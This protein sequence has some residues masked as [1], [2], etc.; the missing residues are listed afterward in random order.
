MRVN[1]KHKKS[2]LL[3]TYH[4]PPD[5]EVGAIRM[6]RLANYLKNHGWDVGVLTVQERYYPDRDD[7]VTVEGITLYRTRMFESVR[8]LF[9]RIKNAFRQARA[10]LGRTERDEPAPPCD[11]SDAGVRFRSTRTYGNLSWI[12]RFV[13]SLI[14]CPDDKQGWIPFAFLKCLQLSNRYDI[15]YS[16][17]P[18]F[19]VNLAP[20]LA[21]FFIRKFVWVAEF[22]DPWMTRNKRYFISSGLSNW[23]EKRCEAMVMKR[24]TKIVVVNEAIERDMID[25]YPLVSGKIRVFYNGYDETEFADMP[26]ERARKDSDTTT[27][28]HA[29]SFYHGRDPGLLLRPLAELVNEGTLSRGRIAVTFLG[30]GEYEGESVLDLA[31]ALHIDG[32]VQCLG[33]LPHKQCLAHIRDADIL[34]LF[35]INQPLQVP[36]KLFEYFAFRKRILSISSGGITDE[37]LDR[38]HVGISVP[39]DDFVAIKSAI[40]TL[41]EAPGFAASD[42]EIN[43]YRSASIFESLSGELESLLK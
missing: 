9:G 32:I 38:M 36:A 23:L 25:R 8:F 28:V 42:E 4:F 39:P 15:V 1:G 33:F 10:A 14:W 12:S 20:L 17:C 19:S 37:L 11:G 31:R 30:D 13:L 7:S 2:I 16:S 43:R 40:V 3:V 5:A 35:N 6:T 21:S 29:G 24:S 27:I 18:A 26:Q 41:I 34:L 22:R